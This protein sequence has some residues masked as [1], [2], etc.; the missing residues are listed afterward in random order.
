MKEMDKT[1]RAILERRRSIRRYLPEQVPDEVIKRCI[2]AA[3]LAPSSSNLQLWEYYH[4][5]S[6]A[7]KEALVK[8]CMSQPAAKT[9]P[10]LIVVVTRHDYWKQRCDANLDFARKVAWEEPDDKP[11]RAS[12]YFTKTIPTLYFDFLGIFGFFKMIFSFFVGLRRPMFR[13]VR[14][15]QVLTMSHKSVG[16]GAVTLMYALGAEGYDSCP[17]EGMDSRRIRK[18]LDLP[19]GAKINMVISCGKRADGGVYGP[20]FRLPVKDVFFE[21]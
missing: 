16:L 17:M 14:A 20:R 4:V 8:A 6:P 18:L 1:F 3:I 21:V 13:E 9:A 2:E 10:N 12:T 5:K 7:K 15:G 19:K 11:I